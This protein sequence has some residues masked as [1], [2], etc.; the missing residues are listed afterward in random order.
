M[1][2]TANTITT[3]QLV[4]DNGK[5]YPD[6]VYHKT[7]KATGNQRWVANQWADGALPTHSVSGDTVRLYTSTENLQGFQ[8]PDG[9]GKLKHYRHIET[10]RTRNGLILGDSSCWARGFAKCTK[11]S[12]TQYRLDLT[13]LDSKL[14]GEP[15]DIYDIEEISDDEVTFSSGRV[16]D[17][18]QQE[19][20]K[21]TPSEIESDVLGL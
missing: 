19:W 9:R 14:M 1:S 17:L 13:S 15:E 8:H 12:S 4:A 7:S 16:Y 11:P 10:I 3:G 21:V 5:G 18:D 20:M 6:D 2:S